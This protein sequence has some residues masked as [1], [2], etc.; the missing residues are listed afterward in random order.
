[1][2][3]RR[4]Q[5]ATCQRCDEWRERRAQAPGEALPQPRWQC[6]CR[7]AQQSSEHAVQASPSRHLDTPCLLSLIPMCSQRPSSVMRT[8]M[9]LPLDSC[10]YNGKKSTEIHGAVTLPC[11]SRDTPSSSPHLLS[12]LCPGLAHRA[13]LTRHC[14][15][16]WAPSAVTSSLLGAAQK[17]HLLRGAGGSP[18]LPCLQAAL[19][20]GSRRPAPRPPLTEHR[21]GGNQKPLRFLPPPRGVRT[22]RLASPHTPL[23]RLAPSSCSLLRP[24]DLTPPTQPSQPPSPVPTLPSP[25]SA[26]SCLPRL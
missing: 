13:P 22:P 4:G 1:M 15:L 18:P 25:V 12:L 11:L 3:S 26:C 20:R 5:R 8:I 10:S 24:G 16:T 7:G 21:Q 14:H 17:S 23:S 9:F 2:L 6:R 19:P